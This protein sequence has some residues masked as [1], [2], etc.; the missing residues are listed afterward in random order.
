M[1][2]TEEIGELEASNSAVELPR[3]TG[4][5]LGRLSSDEVRRETHDLLLLAIT[6]ARRGDVA[7]TDAFDELVE[8]VLDRATS[9]DD[10][11]QVARTKS[12]A[13]LYSELESVDA[14]M[15]AEG[16]GTSDRRDLNERRREILEA[17]DEHDEAIEES[18]RHRSALQLARGAMLDML[19]DEGDARREVALRFDDQATAELDRLAEQLR[20]TSHSENVDV[21]AEAVE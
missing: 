7:D 19:S 5:V 16:E 2:S 12:T 18:C 4:R 10:A 17:L 1:I 8:E 15:E 11:L 20:R 6:V 9:L 21:V 3:R 13:E 14:A